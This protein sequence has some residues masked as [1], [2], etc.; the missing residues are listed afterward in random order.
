LKREITP[1]DQTRLVQ[2]YIGKIGESA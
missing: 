1:E 2:N